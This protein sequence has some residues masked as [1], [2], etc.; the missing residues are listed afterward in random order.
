MLASRRL[1]PRIEAPIRVLIGG[2]PGHLLD[3]SQGGFRLLATDSMDRIAAGTQIDCTM[4][5][6]S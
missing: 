1:H 6:P 3:V 2:M 5:F 4:E